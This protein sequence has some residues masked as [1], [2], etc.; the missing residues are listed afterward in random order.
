[1][2]QLSPWLFII[3]VGR[4]FF[5]KVLLVFFRFKS[6]LGYCNVSLSF[7]GS[8]SFPPL[9]G[10]INLP[11]KDSLTA[12]CDRSLSSR[13]GERPVLGSVYKG[14]RMRGG[15]VAKCVFGYM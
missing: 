15:V 7:V 9:K 11:H 5:S 8:D 4:F 2:L 3:I 6:F 10:L 13:K 1:M 14:E 12:G